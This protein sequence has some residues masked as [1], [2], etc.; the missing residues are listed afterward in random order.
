MRI[1]RT[2]CD[3]RQAGESKGGESTE[4]P[5]RINP[6]VGLPGDELDI[7][8]LAARRRALR[9]SK[10]GP[11]PAATRA[12]AESAPQPV[13]AVGAPS[14]A[15][16]TAQGIAAADVRSRGT[17]SSGAERP[18]AAAGALQAAQPGA[19]RSDNGAVVAAEVD[20]PTDPAAAE[21]LSELPKD[22]AESVIV[23]EEQHSSFKRQQAAAVAAAARQKPAARKPADA[24]AG[25]VDV[26]DSAKEAAGAKAGV[27]SVDSR[28]ELA[29]AEPRPLPP[30]RPV[31]TKLSAD[32]WLQSRLAELEHRVDGLPAAAVADQGGSAP[33]ASLSLPYGVGL[34]G[35]P[36][37]A[38]PTVG[39][40]GVQQSAAPDRE[41]KNEV[42]A[43]SADRQDTDSVSPAEQQ[44]PDGAEMPD[45]AVLEDGEPE[46]AETGGEAVGAAASSALV[47]DASVAGDEAGATDGGPGEL[48]AGASHDLLRPVRRITGA[49]PRF[50][51]R[52]WQHVHGGDRSVAFTTAPGAQE[53]A[54]KQAQAPQQLA[55]QL[56]E[57]C[58][59]AAPH[60]DLLP[61]VSPHN[62]AMLGPLSRVRPQTA[63]AQ[64]QAQSKQAPARLKARA[65]Q[66]GSR[67][68][69]PL[70]LQQFRLTSPQQNGLPPR[71]LTAP[72]I[73]QRLALEPAWSTGTQ[74]ESP[75][76]FSQQRW[77]PGSFES[78]L[79]M[80]LV[81]AQLCWLS[82]SSHLTQNDALLRL[83]TC[84]NNRL[85]CELHIDR[86]S[87][88]RSQRSRVRNKRPVTTSAPRVFAAPAR[89][90][91]QPPGPAAHTAPPV[92]AVPVATEQ[93]AP[94]ST[95]TAEMPKIPAV[96]QTA[97]V[98]TP[99][100]EMPKLPATEPA[101]PVSTS[102]A[103]MPKMPA[104]RPVAA[105]GGG[106]KQAARLQAAFEH[107]VDRATTA[108][109]QRRPSEP[110]P[111]SRQRQW[112]DRGPVA[113]RHAKQPEAT[114]QVSVGGPADMHN[115]LCGKSLEPL[116]KQ[117][118]EQDELVT[119]HVFVP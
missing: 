19:E 40:S 65:S 44:P 31:R 7:A 105:A 14:A 103:A 111:T 63:T 67:D 114:S 59:S 98:S 108:D 25:S 68:A 41:N 22:A 90:A 86:S 99:T 58:L 92:P 88:R 54:R 82:C 27:L 38:V 95:A 47:A 3:C 79:L 20:L 53:A 12:T 8:A 16:G 62:R 36:P 49:V 109:E 72:A 96:H 118:A 74:P 101:A 18:L 24:G 87:Y 102:I 33:F 104:A 29:A 61:E 17:S 15:A 91:E 55:E 4:P 26:A 23:A 116:S 6:P 48:S 106:S 64:Q 9:L 46:R 110:C 107:T 69:V 60:E 78:S 43:L 11:Q 21:A 39:S 113:G 57:V 84:A 115:A 66:R 70:H 51:Q 37:G 50:L 32:G 73:T 34:G 76:K 93:D 52:Q 119:H 81:V 30:R 28:A 97:P 5:P 80:C 117:S 56:G 85:T 2:I 112:R 94:D 83:C 13:S 45:S 71:T 89:R 42:I 1:H 35:S 77:V 100:A 75:P 10:K